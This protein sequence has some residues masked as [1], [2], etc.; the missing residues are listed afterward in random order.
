MHPVDTVL[1]F[2]DRI[3]ERNADKL[4]ELMTEH[5]VFIDSYASRLASVGRRRLDQGMARLR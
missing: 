4:A 3:N 1:Q 5:H 2:L